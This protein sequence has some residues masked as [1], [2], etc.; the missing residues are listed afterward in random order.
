MRIIALADIHSKLKNLGLIRPEL[1]SCD[2][3]VLCGDI[4]HFGGMSEA[5]AIL[6]EIRAVNPAVLA[7]AGNVDRKDVQPYLDGE[8]IGLHGTGK[9]VGDIGFFGVGGSNVTPLGT[10]NEIPD[11]EILGILEKG[12][13]DVEQARIKIIVSH[14]PPKKTKVDRIFLGLHVGSKSLRTFI[15]QHQPDICLT[16]HIH[17]ARGEDTI[18]KTRILNPG[19][20]FKGGYVDVMID[21]EGIKAQI[22][23]V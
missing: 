10:P 23:T 9:A 20:F 15:E 12:Y 5:A 18:G 2:L 6:D 7:V 8:G 22:R 21:E 19:P 16:G 13:A 3:V 1:A 14:P 11:K 17:E 4:T